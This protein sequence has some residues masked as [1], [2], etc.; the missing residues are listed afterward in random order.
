MSNFY[1]KITNSA[2]SYFDGFNNFIVDDYREDRKK[3]DDFL[4]HVNAVY[5]RMRALVW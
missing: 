2:Q 1:K 5:L 3:V 4:G